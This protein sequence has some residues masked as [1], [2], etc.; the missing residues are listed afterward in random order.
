MKSLFIRLIN[1]LPITDPIEV[2][3][4]EL[5]LA[6]E[7]A[8]KHKVFPLVYSRIQN[9]RNLFYPAPLVDEFLGQNRNLYLKGVALS[10]KQEA[11][12]REV[13]ALLASKGIP[14]VVIRGNAIAEELYGDANSRTSSDIDILIKISDALHADQI[15][16][17]A[18][19]YRND[20]I[21][22]KFWF[23]RIHHAVYHC[24]RTDKLIEIHWN[25][26][27]P[28]F[29]R[30]SS[31]EIWEGVIATDSNRL[32]LSP[33]MSMIM[34]F[35]HHHMHSFREVKILADIVWSF[36]KYENNIDW[37][38]FHSKLSKAGLIKTALITV[39]Q[40]RSVWDA[41]IRDLKGLNVLYQNLQKTHSTG[42]ILKS[43]FE[44]DLNRGYQF[45]HAGDTLMA[46]FA[47]D[48]IS[49]VIRSYS[50]MLFPSPAVIKELYENKASWSL[51]M[52]YLKFIRWRVKAWRKTYTSE[53]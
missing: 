27:I 2:S 41:D 42:H 51:P 16:S 15:L 45:Q 44:M 4:Y 35:I 17:D 36:H 11:L 30:L 52:N 3:S 22:L 33:E 10:A 34:L 29:F 14:Y 53:V 38:S 5:S 18:G 25:F 8:I 24:P 40:I 13:S 49:T 21:P 12:E 6:G 48:G 43:F 28:S 26:G 9:R 39:S 47:L 32:K 7:L 46:R 31:E 37:E 23:Y 20:S 50:K 1:P 19:F